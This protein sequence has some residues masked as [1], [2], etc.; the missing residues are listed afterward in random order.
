MNSLSTIP[1]LVRNAF[2]NPTH[3]ILGL[4]DDL[5]TISREQGIQLDWQAGRCRVR[6]CEGASTNWIE[7]PM[8]KSV[9]RAALARIAVLC[10]QQKPNSVS[11]YGGKS[12]LMVGVD[13]TV[14]ICVEFVNTP[15]EQHLELASLQ[16]EGRGAAMESSFPGPSQE[17]TRTLDAGDGT[18]EVKPPA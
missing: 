1:D 9:V 5:L 10:N 6:L 7:V 18:V 2:T 3:G 4:V 15:D 11:P 14:P 17:A 16:Y 8:R 13:P 12:E